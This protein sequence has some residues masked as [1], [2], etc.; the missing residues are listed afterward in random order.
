MHKLKEWLWRYLPLEIVGT[1]VAI[2]AAV[3]VYII[4]DNRIA[5]AYAGVIGE[6]I[7]YYGFLFIR[8]IEEHRAKHKKEDKVFG[9]VEDL[10][11]IRNIILE[12]G[13]A[14]LLDSLFIRPFCMYW[15]PIWMESY[16]FGILVGKLAAD[17]IFYI[18]TVISYELEK[19]YLKD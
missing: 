4:T 7:G 10:K 17:V 5:A 19:K 16:A 2:S 3:L 8:D 1:V 6:N 13:V 12:F 11:I 15:F 9:F 18:P 14:E